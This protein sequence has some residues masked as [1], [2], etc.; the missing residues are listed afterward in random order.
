MIG[1]GLGGFMDG[2]KQGSQIKQQKEDNARKKMLAERDD[3]EY[4]RAEDNRKAIA[5]IAAGAQ[6]E[7]NTQVQAG[8]EQPD[9]F[10]GF[11]SD[12]AI[13]KLRD[14]YLSQGNMADAEKVMQ[15]GE[16]MEAKQGGKLFKSALVKAQTGDAAG[17]LGDVMKLGKIGGY[18]NHGYEVLGHE[19]IV[20]PDGSLMGYR[21]KM[22]TPDGKDLVQDVPT[23]MLPKVIA[24]FANPEAAWQSQ[25]AAGEAERKKAEELQTYEEKKK[26]DKQY[27]TGGDKLRSDAITSLRKRLDGGLTGEDQKFDDLPRDQQEDMINREMELVKGQPGLGGAGAREEVPERRVLVDKGTG[28]PVEQPAQAGPAPAEEDEDGL[29]EEPAAEPSE[30]PRPE[31]EKKPSKVGDKPQSPAEIAKRR[32]EHQAFMVQDADEALRSGAK[33]EAVA[34]RLAAEGVPEKMWPPQLRKAAQMAGADQ[35]GLGGR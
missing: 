18:L 24:T 1:I 17:A 32:E 3:A 35:I 21:I 23:A 15:W 20:K 26:I 28:R 2:F 30:E 34:M 5:D 4:K 9:N 6:T 8:K 29:A 11:W 22:K 7:F 27:S 10:D 25:V 14:T 16:S 19:N 13:P 33:P 31:P 12:Y